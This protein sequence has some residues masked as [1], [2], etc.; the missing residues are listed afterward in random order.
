VKIEIELTEFEW[1]PIVNAYHT[2][3]EEVVRLAVE[4][5]LERYLSVDRLPEILEGNC[6]SYFKEIE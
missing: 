5:I 2:A 1:L 3:Y 4:N 6:Q